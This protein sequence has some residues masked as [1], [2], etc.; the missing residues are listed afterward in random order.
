MLDFK[1][2]PS[3]NCVTDL[4][5]AQT[6]DHINCSG[7]FGVSRESFLNVL[8]KKI[9]FKIDHSGV[10][11]HSTQI[12]TLEGQDFLFL[13]DLGSCMRPAAKKLN[14]YT[15]HETVYM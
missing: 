5:E 11:A 13:S 1:D 8:S 9:N 2:L 12:W 10:F 4:L 3:P 14:K 7:V 6:F 15:E